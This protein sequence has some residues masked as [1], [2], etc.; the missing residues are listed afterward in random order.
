MFFSRPSYSDF[1]QTP[2]PPR[3][4]RVLPG[5]V[6]QPARPQPLVQEV[7]LHV[8]EPRDELPGPR[9]E[10]L[11]HVPEELHEQGDVEHVLVHRGLV[12]LSRLHVIC[13]LQ[14][15]PQML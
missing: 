2:P 5:H 1:Q 11:G 6:D 8:E 12:L 14:L 7:A 15:L 9:A 4:A 3:C 10:G 13:L